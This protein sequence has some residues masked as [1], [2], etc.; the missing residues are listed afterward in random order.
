MKTNIHFWS[1]LAHF[2]LEWEIMQTKFIEKIKTHILCSVTFFPKIY[3]FIQ[4]HIF[5]N[6]CCVEANFYLLLPNMI[7]SCCNSICLCK[8]RFNAWTVILDLGQKVYTV[9][10]FWC[11][12]RPTIYSLWTNLPCLPPNNVYG[13]CVDRCDV[14]HNNNNNNNNN[15]N[16]TIQS[17]TSKPTTSS[18]IVYNFYNKVSMPFCP[19]L[20]PSLSLYSCKW[21]ARVHTNGTRECIQNLG[22]KH[23]LYFPQITY[24][25]VRKYLTATGTGWYPATKLHGVTTHMTTDD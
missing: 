23:K 5:S 19:I 11:Y 20:L 2:F 15:N 6:F 22:S 18:V 25:F 10:L 3:P 24:I 17:S 4:L 9:T 1:Y 13:A 16:K 14:T 12:Y 21:Y 7:A 8:N